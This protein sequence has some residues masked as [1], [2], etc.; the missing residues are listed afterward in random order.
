MDGYLPKPVDREALLAVI[1]RNAALVA[2]PAPQEGF[3]I[4]TIRAR[5]GGDEELVS[6]LLQL[7]LDS[8]PDLMARVTEGI[9]H[10]DAAQVRIAT[11][12]V[13]GV[14]A[15]FSAAGVVSAA[16]ALESAAGE[17]TVDWPRIASGWA[18]LQLP[19]QRLTSGV[20]DALRGTPPS[21]RQPTTA[22][23]TQALNI[24]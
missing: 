23:A 18:E 19:L 14:A 8:C 22:D 24:A 10:R 12:T 16:A 5:L 11:H 13:R 17:T 6:Q 20:R 1:E 3:D 9:A 2:T 7:F 15:Q 4:Q 21:S